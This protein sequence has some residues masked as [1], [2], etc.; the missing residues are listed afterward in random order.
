VVAPGDDA[1]GDAEREGCP[2][3]HAAGSRQ[4]IARVRAVTR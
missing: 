2:L 4:A 3:V 1:T